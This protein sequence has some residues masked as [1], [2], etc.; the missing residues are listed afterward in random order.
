[1]EFRIL[2]P[3]EVVDDDGEILAL[4]GNGPRALLAALLLEHGRA[5]TRDRLVAGLWETP[6]ATASHAVEVYVS[7]L[8]RTLGG[9]RISCQGHSYRVDVEPD[10]LDLTRFR[11]L[12]RIGR[13]AGGAGDVETAADALAAALALWRGHP[14][15]CLNGEPL[16]ADARGYLEE[17]R[18]AA[19]EAHLDALLA[20]GRHHELVPE[21]RR[22]V[23][24]HPS[25][26][27][28]WE[29][30]M[31]ALYRCGRQVDA[32]EVFA[33]LRA[34]LRDEL[35]IEPGCGLRDLQRR[36]LMHDPTLAMPPVSPPRVPVSAR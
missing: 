7:R 21:L 18:V 12:A 14:L 10:E 1:M 30:L 36:I 13:D 8:R 26:E 19:V 32:L 35:G 11:A 4:G 5:V 33:A 31:L 27:R 34:R 16:A 6:P 3:I 29:R 2:G 23:S 17:E 20:L 15:A 24:E 25:R 28:L 22:L 9:G